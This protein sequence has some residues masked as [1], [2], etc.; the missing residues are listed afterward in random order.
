MSRFRQPRF[1]RNA[2]YVSDAGPAEIDSM[3]ASVPLSAGRSG[4]TFPLAWVSSIPP[5]NAAIS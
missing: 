3:W 5:W 1:G 4:S 2:V